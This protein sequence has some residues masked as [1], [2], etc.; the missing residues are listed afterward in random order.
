MKIDHNCHLYKGK[1]EGC[2]CDRNEKRW[3]KQF[4]ESLRF[5]YEKTVKRVVLKTPNTKVKK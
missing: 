4:N 2:N 3:R 1:D 5:P